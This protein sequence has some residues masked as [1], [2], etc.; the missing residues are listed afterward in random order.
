MDEIVVYG[1]ESAHGK[2][3]WG[4]PNLFFARLLQYMEM[5]QYLRKVCGGSGM[6]MA[7]WVGGWSVGWATQPWWAPS[8]RLCHHH[9]NPPNHFIH[10][11]HATNTQALLPHHPD[12]RLAGLLNPLD[13]PHHPRVRTHARARGHQPDCVFSFADV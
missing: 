4:D 12:L 7:G 5:P 2:P 6:M 10:A 11:T 8:H 13:A 9:L 1:D 3:G